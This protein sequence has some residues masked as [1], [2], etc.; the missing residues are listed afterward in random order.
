MLSQFAGSMLGTALGD[1]LGVPLEGSPFFKEVR[2]IHER[3]TD[4]TAMMIGIAES[5]VECRGLDEDHLA[6]RFME[7]FEIEPWRGYGSGP[8]RIFQMM[9]QGADWNEELDK[10]FYPGGS[11]GN[12]SAMRVAP[13]G[14]FYYDADRG[15][16]REAVRRTS[17]ITHSHPL[18]VEGAAMEAYAVALALQREENMLERLEEFTGEDIY[19]EKIQAAKRLLNDKAGR[20]RVVQELGNGIEAFNSVPT[21]IFSFLSSPSFEEALVYAVSLGGDADTIGAMCGAVAGAWW[22][23]TEIPERWKEKL[24]NRGYL[25]NLAGKLFRIK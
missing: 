4:D 11:Y 16:L 5:L 18:A 8:P 14:L 12:G 22:G 1:S 24:E 19:R 23:E 9:R 17:R 10:S 7:N 21:A 2:E 3:Y 20:E 25:E 6:M 13:V 15:E